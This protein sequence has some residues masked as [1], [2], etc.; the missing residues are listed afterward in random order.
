M[1]SRSLGLGMCSVRVLGS[2]LSDIS[3]SHQTR[4]GFSSQ[5]GFLEAIGV[6]IRCTQKPVDGRRSFFVC[7][8]FLKAW[9]GPQPLNVLDFGVLIACK[10]KME[11]KD[12]PENLEPPESM[13]T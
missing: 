2:S 11:E 4:L 8:C 3:L 9:E 10:S 1:Q 12:S 6:R 7:Q 13:L 5:I